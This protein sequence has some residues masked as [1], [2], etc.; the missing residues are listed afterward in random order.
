MARDGNLSVARL[1]VARIKTDTSTTTIMSVTLI[2]DNVFSLVEDSFYIILA[3]WDDGESSKT[4]TMV[5]EGPLS[6]DLL[7][8]LEGLATREVT[9]T[10]LSCCLQR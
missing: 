7:A 10:A 8:S 2:V 9:V 6:G 5:V 3:F 4:T 1:L